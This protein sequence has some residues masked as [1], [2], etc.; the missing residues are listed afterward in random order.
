[1]KLV[2]GQEYTFKEIQLVVCGECG[3]DIAWY[4]VGMQEIQNG[5][6]SHAMGVCVKCHEKYIYRYPQKVKIY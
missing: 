1:M 3:G 5:P 2:K 6:L 4:D